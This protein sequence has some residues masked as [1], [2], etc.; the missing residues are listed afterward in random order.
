MKFSKLA[1]ITAFTA[2]VASFGV[3][4][5]N[6]GTI[7]FTGNVVDSPC[8]IANKSLNQE[9]T[10]GQL[11]RKSLEAGNSAEVGFDIELT[12]CDLNT[13]G[14]G[15]TPGAPVAIKT[16]E[17]TFTGQNY[18]DG[19]NTLLATSTGNTN[20]LGIAIDGFKFEEAKSVI[21]QMVNKKGGNTL[22]FKALA[23]AVTANEAVAEGQFS[24]ITN[25]RI[26]YQ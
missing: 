9:I 3:L 16:M 8:N 5:E 25:F 26:S 20:N 14:T 1:L 11:S 23:K 22:S 4:A 10:F 2:S 19:T 12:N 6:T 21:S 13:T 7:K 18:A 17:L 15:S 24:A